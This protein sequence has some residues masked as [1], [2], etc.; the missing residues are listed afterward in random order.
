MR[1]RGV[2]IL[3]W[4]AVFVSAQNTA[5][6]STHDASSTFST[7][8]NLVMVPV[9]IRDK[10]GRAVGTLTKDDFVL[11]DRGKPQIITR[12]AIEKASDLANVKPIP[13]VDGAE[14]TTATPVAI[15]NRFTAYLFDDLHIEFGDLVRARDAVSRK[16]DALQPTERVAIFTTSGRY[17]LDFTDDRASLHEMLLK[18]Q[19]RPN[20]A[21]SNCPPMTFYMASLID[22]NDPG[23][24]SAAVDDTMACSGFDPSMRAAAVTMAQAAAAHALAVGNNDTQIN[25]AVMTDVIRRMNAAPGQRNL[26]LVS[27]GF[28]VTQEFL[29]HE[30]ELVDR[31]IRG[32]III[33]ALDARGLYVVDAD[34]SQPVVSGSPASAIA[35]SRY[36]HESAIAE[37]DVLADVS[38]GTGGTFFQNNNDFDEAIRRM[39]Q[40][41]EF[42]YVLGFNPQ[43]LKYDGMF[44]S[45]KVTLKPKSALAIEARRG[46]YAPKHALDST[47]QAREEISEAMFSRDE[48][49]DIPIQL[50]TQF[51]KSAADEARLAVVVKI[52]LKP[53]QFKK[54]EGR[55]RNDLAIVSGI[56]DRNGKLVHALQKNVEMRLKEETF[57]QRLAAGLTVK[58]SFDVIPGN[59]VIR[60]VVRDKEGALMT[61]RNGVVQIP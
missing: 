13:S 30:S 4:A 15:A 40:P 19:P 16:I 41:P 43:N 25:L 52:D 11:T 14:G 32:N 2:F 23:A 54:E 45:L 3:G 38:Y 61:A 44:H 7:R 9:V 34:L 28:L 56:F 21:V 26:I 8:V 47:E 6:I 17:M 20:P 39:A 57:E 12:F 24:L 46:Y 31:A 42:V 36:A 58:T 50:Q 18:I 49:Q 1:N 55:N 10:Q 60:V 27:D 29:P 59:Y 48:T 53:L 33:S 37:A 35:R 22:R 5:E 51:F